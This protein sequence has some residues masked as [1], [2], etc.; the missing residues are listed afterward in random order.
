MEQ[1][2]LIAVGK[3]SVIL[4][5]AR[6]KKKISIS[7]RAQKGFSRAVTETPGH[8][9]LWTLETFFEISD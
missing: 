9:F 6:F 7:A 5:S 4:L 8:P 3:S 2:R 1:F